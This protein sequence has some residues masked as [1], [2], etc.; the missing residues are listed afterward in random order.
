MDQDQY[1]FDRNCLE[2]A[3]ERGLI[4]VF[5]N[6]N[7]LQLDLDTDEAWDEYVRRSND[8]YRLSKNFICEMNVTVSASGLPH[9][10]VTL[11]F[12]DRTF[13]DRERILMQAAL[14]DDPLRV[15]LNTLRLEYGVYGP[16]RLF[17]VPT[18]EQNE[19]MLQADKDID[20]IY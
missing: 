18:Q 7:Q 17:A 2:V 3:A 16:C 19:K 11:T 9:R 5:P 4:V 14:G 12:K 8:M 20:M 10:H 13:D 1:E 6:D 15:F